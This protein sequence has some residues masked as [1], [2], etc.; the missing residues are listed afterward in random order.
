MQ[1]RRPIIIG[2]WKMNPSL[3]EGATLVSQI[4]T[5]LPPQIKCDV[6]I[7]PPTTHLSSLKPLLENSPIQLGAQSVSEHNNG[8]YTGEIS[9]S[10]LQEIGCKYVILGHSERRQYFHESNH[11]IH[12]KLQKALEYQ[13]IPILCVG[14]SLEEREKN[15]T[16]SVI[17]KQLDEALIAVKAQSTLIIAYEPIWAI[18]TGKVAS[19]EDAQN[20]HAFI[21]KELA[22]KLSAETAKKTPIL[23]GGSMKPDNAE[24][25]LSQPDVD[26]GLIG[27][28]SLDAKSF[29]AIINTAPI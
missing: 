6:V 15:K 5:Q 8:A 7:C 1:T 24:S 4:Q 21:R 17:K 19:K 12:Q 28:A 16:Q 14:E 29:I 22:Q 11:A 13:L 26:G 27:G 23:Y 2:N 25:L 9:A 20:I 18:G 3:A 10:M